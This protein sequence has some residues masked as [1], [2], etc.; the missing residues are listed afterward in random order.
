MSSPQD[1]LKAEKAKVLEDARKAMEAANE[2]AQAI[3]DDLQALA[4]AEAI[5]AKYGLEIRPAAQVRPTEPAPASPPAKIVRFKLKPAPV[6]RRA[7]NAAVKMIR[8]ANRPL[9]VRELFAAM[10]AQGIEIA[11]KRPE[12]TFSAFLSG[13]GEL[14]TAGHGYWWLRGVPRPDANG[15]DQGG[16]H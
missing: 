8:E 7:Q 5:A 2:R 14:E 11:G 10:P 6:S 16:A 12:S 15:A 9:P 4:Q 3:D 1:I 13:C